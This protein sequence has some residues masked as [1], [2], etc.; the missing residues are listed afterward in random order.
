MQDACLR[1]AGHVRFL[2]RG[3]RPCYHARHVCVGSAR[4]HECRT[5]RQRMTEQYATLG[6]FRRGWEDTDKRWRSRLWQ[7]GDSGRVGTDVTSRSASGRATCGVRRSW[8]RSRPVG[9]SSQ[10]GI[11]H[12]GCVKWAGGRPTADGLRYAVYSLRFT[13]YGSRLALMAG[14]T[15]RVRNRL[16]ITGANVRTAA[17]YSLHQHQPLAGDSAVRSGHPHETRTRGLPEWERR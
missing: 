8:P 2:S 4:R 3:L 7:A 1:E 17:R 14:E 6:G 5:S 9:P 12:G 10:A 16:R 13:V 11:Q 15:P